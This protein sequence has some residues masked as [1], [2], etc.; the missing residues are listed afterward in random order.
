[1]SQTNRGIDASRIGGL[2]S[3]LADAVGT[4]VSDR[5][6]LS[7]LEL[8]DDARAMGSRIAVVA[9]FSFVIV[10]GYALLCGAIAILAGAWITP[11]GGWILVGGFN[12]I[13]GCV[14]LK[15]AVARLTFPEWVNA[16]LDDVEAP[17]AARHGRIACSAGP[18]FR[19]RQRPSPDPASVVATHGRATSWMAVSVRLVTYGMNH[20]DRPRAA[21]APAA[22]RRE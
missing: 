9:C 2:V 17:R 6:G 18:R 3:R 14:G 19:P 22:R 15:I 16:T 20:A 5:L 10:V 13:A 1:M 7:R 4:R 11:A 12:L 8:T 21:K